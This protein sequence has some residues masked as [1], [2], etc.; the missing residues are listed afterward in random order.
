MIEAPRAYARVA[1]LRA[2]DGLGRL[3]G[4]DALY[5]IGQLGRLKELLR[6]TQ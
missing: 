6:Q 4:T 2:V 3:F 1:L 5:I